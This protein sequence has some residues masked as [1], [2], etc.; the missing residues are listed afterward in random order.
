MAQKWPTSTCRK[1][2]A[3]RK[4]RQKKTTQKPRKGSANSARDVNMTFPCVNR[5][6]DQSR[7]SVSMQPDSNMPQ[8]LT[9]CSPHGLP[10][11]AV[12]QFQQQTYIS[13]PAYTA[14][15]SEPTT[16]PKPVSSPKPSLSSS[17]QRKT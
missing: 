15:V 9:F 16:T 10:M 1:I 5:V 6:L 11:M 12:T 3:T 7:V 2:A 13:T 8:Q 17:E 4:T 14:T